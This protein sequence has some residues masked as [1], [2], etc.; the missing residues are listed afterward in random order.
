MIALD[1]F[2]LHRKDRDGRGGGICLYVKDTLACENIDL[3]NYITDNPLVV[4]QY[5]MTIKLNSI[6]IALG[7]LYRPP[8]ANVN[9]AV[10][11]LDP[12]LSNF[13]VMYDHVV[14]LGDVNVNLLNPDNN[15]SQC[16]QSYDLQQLINEPTRITQNSETLLDPIF[17]S[18]PELCNKA[19]TLNVNL[20]TDHLLVYCEAFF[21]KPRSKQKFVTIRD[22]KNF[23]YANFTSDLHNVDWH[24]IVQIKNIDDKVE[25]L[26]NNILSVFDRNAPVRTVRVSKPYAPWL[27]SNLKMIFHQR[28]SALR[29]YKANKTVEN[30][31]SYKALRNFALACMRQEKAAHL[32]HVCGENNSSKLYKTLKGM[33]IQKKTSADIP[34]H[35]RNP[36]AI[37]HYFLSVYKD[38][39]NKCKNE[40]EYFNNHK[41][42]GFEPFYF[43]MTDE[44][45]ILSVLKQI[46][47]NACGSDGITV[48]MLKLSFPVIGKYITHL[49]N[50]CIEKNYFPLC[51][52]E[53]IVIPIP[54]TN[55]PKDFS[56]LRPISLLPVMAKIIEK[57]VYKQLKNHFFNNNIIPSF[58]SGFRE[59][60]STT[61]A[62][63]QVSDEIIR[64]LDKNQASALVLLDFSKAFDTINHSL[65]LA[66]CRY[67][68]LHDTAIQFLSNYLNNRKQKVSLDHVASKLEPVISGVPQ[69]STLGPLLFLIYVSDLGKAVANS[70]IIQYADDTQLYVSFE[71]QNYASVV[72]DLNK[73]ISS[74]VNYAEKN[75]LKLNANK[76]QALLFSSR[77]CYKRIQDNSQILVKDTP[78][79]I[80]EH[81]KNLGVIFDKDLRFRQHIS[82]V[83]KNCFAVLK[84]LLANRSVMSYKLKKLICESLVISKLTYCLILYYP[85]LDQATASR[86]QMVQNTCC[87]LVTNLRKFDHISSS[88][89][90]LKWLNI[91]ELYTY[92]MACFVQR[93]I[94]NKNPSYLY[95][96]LVFRADVR[97]RNLRHPFMLTMPQHKTSL[98]KRCFSYNCVKLF[99]SL[100]ES[101]KNLHSKKFKR[102]VKE[103]LLSRH[104]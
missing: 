97:Q 92:H 43:N 64:G 87:R 93:L 50:I 37:N 101:L 58:Q 22:F 41:L 30:W 8:K 60:C 65:L 54:K 75:S 48:E 29:S 74:I 57:I 103:F 86:L 32:E 10:Q 46:K 47:S 1:G 5:W 76:S 17:V 23:N 35:L 18:F 95:H 33:N 73:D 98:F 61:T 63:L 34:P 42:G 83:V 59:G 68:G 102:A 81:A 88:F 15:I 11:L 2:S 53:A 96:K 4:E 40:I 13:S 55:D 27:T 38:N 77:N 69:G 82:V 94:E 19:G 85:C 21:E 45:E 56:D 52:K 90:N 100:P 99:N 67:Y 9:N 71:P 91:E 72:T 51:W 36:S 66:K 84:L 70:K 14:V 7:V 78:I 79:S 89:R 24:R 49:L 31:R 104:R 26:S 12:L 6:T 62:L 39:N 44:Q 20:M 3:S 25:F 80:L 28:D 16:F